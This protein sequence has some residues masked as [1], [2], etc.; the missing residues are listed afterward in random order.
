MNKIV[1]ALGLM[2]IS[3]ATYGKV[4][5]DPIDLRLEVETSHDFKQDTRE[6]YIM[7]FCARVAQEYS[8]GASIEDA[9]FTA[10]CA[11]L[12]AWESNPEIYSWL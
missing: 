5:F 6:M 11:T 1:I 3:A 12:K 4:E 9:C 8:K 2:L 10:R 7:F